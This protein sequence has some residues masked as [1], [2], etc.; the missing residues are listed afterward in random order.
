MPNLSPRG[1]KFIYAHEGCPLTA[2]LDPVGIW[3][4]GP[5]LTAATGAIRPV[6]GMTITQAEADRIFSQVM[7]ATY[8]PAVRRALGA[9][10]PQHV[11][12]GASS[13][14]FNCGP[15]A[16][17]TASWV[18][19]W[20]DGL[21]AEVKRRLS[22]WNKGGGRVL[23][24]LTR[25]R[26]EE[27]DII[28]DNAWPAGIE[29][30]APEP[31]VEWAVFVVSVT[32]EDIVN[33]RDGLRSLGYDPGPIT[34]RVRYLAVNEFQKAH[35]LTVDGKIGRATLAT[36]QREIDRKRQ[37]DALSTTGKVGAPAG[38]AAGA[39]IEAADAGAGTA[40]DIVTTALMGGVL[41][42]IVVGAVVL[43]GFLVY[44]YRGR[45]F[46]AGK[47]TGG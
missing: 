3:T 13:F 15:G 12:D 42:P 14:T 29:G 28:I 4:I 44:R 27:G 36:L 39:G 5:G 46:G 2:Y 33:V 23:P 10:I 41:V 6:R 34:G 7:A 30:P 31:T 22:L 16:I 35:N 17:G 43:T 1:R 9:N 8:E 19:A 47:V 38:A 37:N 18:K 32:A 45:I 24:G 25:R 26:K 11:H 20:K 40:G 21:W